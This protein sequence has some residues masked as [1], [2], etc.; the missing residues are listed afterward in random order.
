MIGAQLVN[1]VLT[2]VVVAFGVVI[3]AGVWA[4]S[5]TA[6]AAMDR[7]RAIRDVQRA[8][9]AITAAAASASEAASR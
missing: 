3:L 2:G 6:V 1:E 4:V 5:I 9:T 8:A 7:R